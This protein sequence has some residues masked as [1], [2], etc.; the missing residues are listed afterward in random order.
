[1]IV[2]DTSILSLAFRRREQHVEA[3]P[4]AELRNL[5]AR[6]TPM[7]IPGIVL[8]ELLSGVRT[9]DRLRLLDQALGSFP[10]LLATRKT[11]VRAAEVANACRSKGIAVTSDD[12]LIAAHAILSNAALFTVDRDFERIASHCGLRLHRKRQ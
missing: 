9:R 12:C 2:L 5:I 6:D 11:H 1:M 10:L 7:A 8:Q 3:S 4:V